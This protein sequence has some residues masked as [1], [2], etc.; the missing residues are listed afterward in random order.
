[1]SKTHDRTVDGGV[2]VLDDESVPIGERVQRLV[3]SHTGEDARAAIVEYG[4]RMHEREADD[5]R[6]EALVRLARKHGFEVAKAD[7][8]PDE[9]TVD[10]PEPSPAAASDVVVEPLDA[11]DGCIAVGEKLD[12]D[13]Q[14]HNLSG[15]QD[16][17]PVRLVVDDELVHEVDAVLDGGETGEISYTLWFD[18]PGDYHV[19]IGGRES[20]DIEVLEPSS[21]TDEEP[22]VSE[23]DQSVP[24]NVR[25]TGIFG[26]AGDPDRNGSAASDSADRDCA[27][28]D[29]PD[30]EPIDV[31]R[32]EFLF[33]P[34]ESV[35]DGVDGTGLV[36]VDDEHYLAIARLGTESMDSV[37]DENRRSL[38][39]YIQPF[40]SGLDFDTE[41]VEV[42]AS[43]TDPAPRISED[44]VVEA[45]DADPITVALSECRE[46]I[47]DA[48]ADAAAER[49]YYVVTRLDHGIA[50]TDGFVDRLRQGGPLSGLMGSG[51]NARATILREVDERIETVDRVL[52]PLD[53]S[54]RRVESRREGREV[55]ARVFATDSGTPPSAT[56]PQSQ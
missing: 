40:L 2:A 22:R 36:V 24:V 20:V 28:D 30:V 37:A 8:R 3:D 12:L 54:F 21:W 44:G 43:V 17:R 53:L 26:R 4:T 46:V 35:P 50:G 41:I 25:S 13:V 56:D 32:C 31:D 42:P 19:E 11:Q 55:L 29:G 23:Y 5:R 10:D 49:E 45:D 47:A 51:E 16:E 39:S 27:E 15:Y 38:R 9:A 6:L 7:F 52:R 14:L 33:D 18:A 48:S 1:M 34:D